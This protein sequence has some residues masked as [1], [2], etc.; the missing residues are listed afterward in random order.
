VSQDR[1]TKAQARRKLDRAV[2]KAN[3]AE[4]ELDAALVAAKDAR[5]TEPEM[6]EALTSLIGLGRTEGEP[7]G[8]QTVIRRVNLARKRQT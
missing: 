8:R 6:R 3:R 1:D 7:A 4:C 5:V 2:Q